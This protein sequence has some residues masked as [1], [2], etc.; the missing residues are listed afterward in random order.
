LPF[1]QLPVNPS[2]HA[3]TKKKC[4]FDYYKGAEIVMSMSMGLFLLEAG[5]KTSSKTTTT[6]ANRSA[7]CTYICIYMKNDERV[8]KKNGRN[9]NKKTE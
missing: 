3:S 4:K 9:N 6:M 7:L 5:S 2:N 1:S 8:T